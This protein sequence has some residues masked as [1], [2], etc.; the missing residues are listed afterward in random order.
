MRRI[1]D[2]KKPNRLLLTVMLLLVL[3][4]TL[5]LSSCREASSVG[6]L[7]LDFSTD[8]S[9]LPTSIAVTWVQISGTRNDDN[10]IAF[11]PQNFQLGS[12]MKITDLSVG[13]WTINVVGYGGNPTEGFPALTS[14]ATDSNVVIQS[15]QTTTAAFVLQYLT[16]GIG[17]FSLTVNWPV[18]LPAF[19]K[20]EAVL[21]GTQLEG[22]IA[23]SSATITGNL[24]VGDYP[25]DIVFTN[26]LGTQISFPYMEMIN[27]YN[28]LTSTGAITFVEADFTQAATPTISNADTTGGQQITISSATSE[29][30]IYYTTDGTDPTTSETK[31]Q[32][33][34][35]FNISE[36][37]TMRAIAIKNGMVNSAEASQE[38]VVAQVATPTISPAGG[39]F[40]VSQQVTMSCA[41]D[42]VVIH[43]T[44]D[45]T[46]PTV[47]SPVYNG[48]L[49]LNSTA[50]VKAIAVKSGMVDSLSSSQSYTLMGTVATPTITSTDATG[51]Q[52]V[53]ITSTTTGA[54]IYY[55]L[56]GT[57]PTVS[58]TKYTTSFKLTAS[59]TV[60]AMAMKTNMTNSAVATKSVTV[61]QVATPTI[62]NADTAGGQQVSITSGT[63]GATIYYTIDGTAPTVSSTKYTASFKL[64][65][66][67]T[68][69][70]LAVK[71]GMVNSAVATKSV[72]VSQV[73]TPV[74]SPSTTT[75]SG[76]VS[77]TLSSTSGATI[78][79]TTNGS[80]PTTASTP[81]NSP[82]TISATTTV[83]AV[84]IKNGMINSTTATKQYTLQQVYTVGSTGP[85]GGVVFYV[86]DNAAITAWKYLEA[87]PADEGEYIY[88]GYD[89]KTGA[90][91]TII[92][93][94]QAN[95]QT[96]VNVLKT[97]ETGSYA[98]KVCDDKS[99][100]YNGKTYDDWFLP[101]KDELDEMYKNR[102]MIGGFSTYWYW[103][104]SEAI[105]DGAWRQAFNNLGGQYCIRERIS[106][107]VRPIRAFL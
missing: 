15:G 21:N 65:A 106:C 74:I 105:N 29:A 94:G 42:S 8:K 72:T 53:S 1:E 52:Q 60:K 5:T 47:S 35:P 58:S 73:A 13:T 26:F 69:K 16:T 97:V 49:T 32:Y 18:I 46:T 107:R 9:I 93:T 48:A 99:V 17:S 41:T 98:A 2:M 96:I 10:T 56:D 14:I 19:S 44:T 62:A 78:Y 100:T 71:T 64:T 43:Y 55:T 7:T 82:F 81:Y 80:N 89:K 86:N 84:A 70:A 104:S 39:L 79:Y 77:V 68:V 75:F 66:T 3:S 102:T 22:A 92:G 45:G 33:T 40:S 25:V 85:A 88:G 24:E 37:K 27:V 50:T 59:K 51:G 6:D 4:L 61:G 23:D 87:A 63:T 67:K 76:T 91:A 30:T 38:V 28:S 57:A 103:S 101:S 36:T 20:V 12:P 95:T 34:A 54:T 90:T 11:I 31:A 83:K